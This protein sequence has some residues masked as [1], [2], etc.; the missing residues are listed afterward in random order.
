MST[1][2]WDTSATSYSLEAR[3][4]SFYRITNQELVAA[5]RIQPG[6]R[7]V[8]LGCGTGLTILTLLNSRLN[9]IIIYAVDQS[10]EM[11]N[12]ARSHIQN[13]T[14]HFIPA[15]A[16]HFSHIIPEKMDRVF[17]NAAFFHF[18]QPEKVLE[19]I[20]RVLKSGGLFLFNLPDQTF[21]FGDGKPSEMR[22]VV[23]T[24]LNRKDLQPEK[25][26]YNQNS[27]ETLAVAMGFTV[28][29]YRILEIPTSSEDLLRFYS[30]PHVG[31]RWFP[32][33]TQEERVALFLKA[34]KTL[35]ANETIPYR[36]AQFI[37]SKTWLR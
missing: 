21:D 9:R 6:M 23:A 24:C 35:P 5:G 31:A 12:R 22:R 32:N 13:P 17:C 7:M 34:F 26:H 3:N 16:D 20:S 4:I 33:C 8:D 30:I 11:L 27:I 29:D 37:L 14:V 28:A 25:Y 19:E 10:P 36:W 1:T 2:P 15:D 18:S